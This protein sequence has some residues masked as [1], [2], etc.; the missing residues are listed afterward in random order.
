MGGGR[1]EPE[2]VHRAEC[3]YNHWAIAV[4][5]SVRTGRASLSSVSLRG[6]MVAER[7]DVNTRVTSYV[8]SMPTLNATRAETMNHGEMK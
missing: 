3:D 5:I 2:A 4:V 8:L 6:W 7:M 1:V